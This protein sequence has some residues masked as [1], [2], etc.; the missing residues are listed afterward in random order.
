MRTKSQLFIMNV[1]KICI[2]LSAFTALISC[3][4]TP[5]ETTGRTEISLDSVTIMPRLTNNMTI[6]LEIK[7]TRKIENNIN[8]Q[9]ASSTWDVELKINKSGNNQWLGSWNI[10]RIR[11]PS[12]SNALSKKLEGIALGFD[13]K[14]SLDST[15]SVIELLNWKEIRNKGLQAMEAIIANT[16][17]F[18]TLDEQ[19][20]NQIRSTIGGMFESKEMVE[21]FAMQEVL[22][23]F[24]LSGMGFYKADTVEFYT[25]TTNPIT[26]DLIGMTVKSV[27]QKAYSDSTCDIQ[28][29]QTVDKQDMK[30]TLSNTMNSLATKK[31]SNINKENVD[32]KVITNF[33]VSL[34]TGLV[35]K[36]TSTKEITAGTE[37]RTDIIEITRKKG[38]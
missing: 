24:T 19:V 16:K 33:T 26:Y 38:K 14:F 25:Y 13:Y 6:N 29:I 34:T 22:L 32:V 23:Y 35:E 36:V 4:E 31:T 15:G 9:T 27:F 3:K 2:I 10:K 7:K 30:K 1:L 28:V 20:E 8:P 17:Q 21:T 5:G 11:V 37:K 12:N 18:E